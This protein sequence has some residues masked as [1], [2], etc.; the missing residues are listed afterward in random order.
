[1]LLPVNPDNKLCVTRLFM[2]ALFFLSFFKIPGII[3]YLMK[4]A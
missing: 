3:S 2:G 4:R 1:M